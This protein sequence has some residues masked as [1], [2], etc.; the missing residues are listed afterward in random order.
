MCLES[1]HLIA[2]YCVCLENNKKPNQV[3]KLLIEKYIPVFKSFLRR[4]PHAKVVHYFVKTDLLVL[5]DFFSKQGNTI[6]FNN[7][8]ELAFWA[9]EHNDKNESARDSVG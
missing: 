1:R 6:R 4:G 3:Q 7:E 8:S 2:G 5:L 9:L